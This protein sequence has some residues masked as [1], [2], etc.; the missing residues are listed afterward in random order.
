MLQKEEDEEEEN[1]EVDAYKE[2]NSQIVERR[3]S[4]DKVVDR[5]IVSSTPGGRHIK[6]K[7]SELKIERS[8]VNN[9]RI[10]IED[11]ID[12]ENI[13]EEQKY[14]VDHKIEE[15]SDLEHDKKSLGEG[16]ERQDKIDD[17]FDSNYYKEKL[18]QKPTWVNSTFKWSLALIKE[19]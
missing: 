9:S 11:F 13:K 17:Q 3:D 12:E 10:G 19:K 7:Q 5:S 18:K 8:S 14:S 16:M 4:N 15:E 1:Q 6:N 2:H